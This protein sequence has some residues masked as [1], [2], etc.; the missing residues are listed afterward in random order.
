MFFTPVKRMAAYKA[1]GVAVP[2]H[3]SVAGR[4]STTSACIRDIVSCPACCAVKQNMEGETSLIGVVEG[5]VSNRARTSLRLRPHLCEST[6]HPDLFKSWC[7]CFV[8]LC[9]GI[10]FRFM[11]SLFEKSYNITAVS[12]YSHMPLHRS[13]LAKRVVLVN[14]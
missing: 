2:Y 3:L 5:E 10:C 4:T 1:P 7:T 14:I 8:T 13:A 12:R 11:L 6:N 9:F